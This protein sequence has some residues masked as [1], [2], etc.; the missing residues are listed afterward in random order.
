MIVLFHTLYV[1]CVD[2]LKLRKNRRLLQEIRETQ[3]DIEEE[4][5]R[6][7][8]TYL[9]AESNLKF[10]PPVYKQRYELVLKVLLD[11]RWRTHVRKVVDFGCAEFGLFYLIRTLYGLTEI[12]E[13]DIDEDLLREY[14]FRLQPRTVDYINKRPLP[15]TVKVFVGSVADPDPVLKDVDVVIAVE[16]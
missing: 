8:T 15:L 3:R 1:F 16:L 9:D 2:Y 14:L 5:N 4:V 7:A 12:L 6:H 10:D 13:V 11:E